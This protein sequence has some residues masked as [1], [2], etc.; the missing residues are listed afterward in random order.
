MKQNDK[1]MTR[2]FGAGKNL[3][4]LVYF[5]STARV[6]L[7]C[8]PVAESLGPLRPPCAGRGTEGCGGAANDSKAGGETDKAED[9]GVFPSSGDRP[10]CPVQLS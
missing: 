10:P 6:V 3:E 5:G 1:G 9:C 4:C 7:F 2:T 8:I